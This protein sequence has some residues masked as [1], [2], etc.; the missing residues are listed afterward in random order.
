M[1]PPRPASTRLPVAFVAGLAGGA[2][3]L[4]TAFIN[5]LVA[6]VGTGP[7]TAGLAPLLPATG[8]SWI[9]A[10]AT[11]WQ[12]LIPLAA[13]LALGAIVFA[14]VPAALRAVARPG[15]APVFLVIWAC[16]VAASAV[17]GLVWA[18]GGIV[19]DWPP[20]RLSFLVRGVQPEV[21]AGA[22]WGL[23]WGWAPAWIAA[24][25][26]RRSE[27]TRTGNRRTAR[28][29][30]LLPAVGFAV[31]LVA[32]LPLASDANRAP[33]PQP[34][35]AEQAPAPVPI[36]Q[37]AVSYTIEDGAPGSDH[38]AGGTWCAGGD[39]RTVL[40]RGD[41]ATGHRAQRLRITNTSDRACRL[42]AYPDVAFDD[43]GGNAMNVLFYRGGSF[44]TEDPGPSVVVLP[45]GA[46]AVADLGWNA[47]APAGATTPGTL[48]VAPS[49][50]ADR[51][52]LPVNTA[53]GELS[54]DI[55]DAG[56]V[57]I[58]AWSAER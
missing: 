35:A 18:V 22:S 17:L 52:R 44:M 36:G 28:I 30:R 15:R 21:G 31:V 11:P 27:R 6:T 55:V 16:V 41:A 48:L 56:A 45:P 4:A 9:A 38:P 2:A 26:G 54:L 23:A 49:A 32:A 40:G 1:T 53:G 19:V 57:A 42:G 50:G 34:P 29:M 10:S 37:P 7:V 33:A 8:P 14:A 25:V 24:A 13:G 46:S 58:T 47:M 20:A 3:W 12:F 51:T 43:A 39:V 5:H